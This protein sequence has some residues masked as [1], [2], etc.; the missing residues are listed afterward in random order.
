MITGYTRV[1]GVIAD[2]I[3]HSLSPMIHNTAFNLLNLDSVYLA[4][5][6]KN[7]ALEDGIK[8]IR[9]LDMQGVNVSMP[10][11]DKVIQYLDELSKEASEIGA[12]NTIVNNDGKLVG[13]NTDGIGFVNS[14]YAK[15][16]K[17]KNKNIVLLGAGGASK[18]IVNQLC[19][20]AVTSIAI[21]KQE[22]ET[23]QD[24]KQYFESVGKK[25]ECNINV[26][27]YHQQDLMEILIKECDIL[28]NG[29][30]LG[31]EKTIDKSPVH[32]TKML[33]NQVVV[34]LIYSPAETLF[35][36]EA[37]KKGCQTLNGLG[38]LLY[39]AAEAFKLWTDQEMPV[40]EVEKEILKYLKNI[41]EEEK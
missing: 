32:T 40:E 33:A 23:Y 27:P 38:M 10:Y 4:F 15:E 19:K 30:N 12:V 39:Q 37:R 20:E 6:V 8:S 41:E 11:K 5:E 24:I 29:T 17:L 1:L 25:Y 34:D 36:S 21:F 22:N 9:S 16:I 18:A 2:P 31:M 26:F 28:I 35:L 3:K 14:L 13:Y 7:R